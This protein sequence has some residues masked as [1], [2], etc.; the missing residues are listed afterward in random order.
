MLSINNP[1][2]STWIFICI[3]LLSVFLFYRS[4]KD[5]TLSYSRTQELK[6]FAIFA[7]IFSHIG[8]FLISDHQF[9]FPLSIMAGVGVNM[10]LFLSGFG[11]TM[12]QMK[13]EETTGTFYRRR[14]LKLLI[15]FW[16][17]LI[18][19]LTLDWFVLQIGYSK[20]F[21]TKAFFG[22]FTQA[23][24]F[25]DLNS[26]FWY[27]TLI[28]FYYLLFPIV[29]SKKYAWLSGIVLY[30]LSYTVIV[31]KPEFL[32]EVLNLYKAHLIAFPAGI[33]IAWLSTHSKIISGRINISRLKHVY[34]KF[35][36]IIYPL[37]LAG[38]LVFIGYFGIHSKVGAEINL[39][40]SISLLT[41]TA[42]IILFLIKKYEYKIL[43]LFG[44]YSYELYLLHWPIMSRYD[45][46]YSYVPAWLAT[47]LYLGLFIGLS[48]LL[49]KVTQYILILLKI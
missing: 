25:N 7:I 31:M 41:M 23:Q 11:L 48:W 15:P 3:F 18:S 9:L 45:I 10:F 29:F 36:K 33:C 8:Y 17:I 26:P 34:N 19:F 24:I 44:L 30:G 46:F 22:I 20:E 21:I 6:G 39:E 38:L 5:N 14:V 12:S 35:E 16:L 27:F 4:Q 49:R 42:I 40:Q 28:L 2:Q 37:A 43:G 1:I 47:V 32:K 13:K